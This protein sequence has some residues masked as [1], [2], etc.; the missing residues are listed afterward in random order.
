MTG[1]SASALRAELQKIRS[2]DVGKRWR[3]GFGD[4]YRHNA[5]LTVERGSTATIVVRDVHVGGD[6][7]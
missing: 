4:G 5:Q 7:R 3:A 6:A 1:E 2:H